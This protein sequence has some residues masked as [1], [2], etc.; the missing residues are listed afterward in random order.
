MLP[1]LNE[2]NIGKFNLIS[3][4]FI[5]IIF[6]VIVININITSKKQDF[7]ILKQEVKNKFIEEKKKEIKFKVDNANQ[8]IIEN[9][10]Q[11]TQVLKNTIKERVNNAYKIANKIY[12]EQTK[13]KSKEEI[14][15]IIKETLR[16]IRYDNGIGYIFMVTMKGKELLFPVAS[17]F[18]NDNVYNLQDKKGDFVIQKE[19]QIV[20]ENKEGFLK[21]FWT[22]PNSHDKEMIYP[23]LTFVK[24]FEKLDLYIGSGMYIDDANKKSQEY[25]KNLLIELNKQNLKEYIIVSELLN[26]DGGNEFAKIIVHPTAIIGKIIGDTKKD[27]YGKE[28]RKE[29]LKGLKDNGQTYLKYSYINPK[30]NIEMSKI[31][32]FVL[33]KQWNWIIGAGFHDDI[34][35]KDINNWQQ[36]L[37]VLIIQNIYLYIGLLI[38]FSIIL[39]LIVFSISKFTNKTILNYKKSVELKQNELNKINKDLEIKIREEVE[40]STKQFKILQEQSKMAA[41]GEMIGNIAHQWRQPLSVISTAATG[42]KVKKEFGIE[43]HNDDMKMLEV[44]NESAQYLSKTID[45]FRDFLKGDTAKKDFYINKILEK[46]LTIEEGVIKNNHLTIVKNFDKD[47]KLHNL[48]H[49]LLQSCVNIINNS[50]DAFENTEEEDRYIFISTK[51]ASEHIEIEIK[52]TAGGIPKNII[53]NIFEPYFTTKHKSQGTGLGLHMTY[54]IINQNMGGLITVK[55]TEYYYNDTD[56]TGAMFTIILP[57]E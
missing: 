15:N 6:T 48:E 49:G 12:N 44:I 18:E 11:T 40:K 4:S 24:G 26:I 9:A 45:S 35:D 41:M 10:K 56:Y 3:T 17:H 16:P 27:L 42:I 54:N 19:I 1:K 25:M 20:K 30:T 36:N 23:K 51:I 8:L 5:L 29:Y 34:I 52:D 46:I 47:I 32:Y 53:E 33:N 21:D 55:N 7:D 43:N 50:K 22:K 31:S 2:Q 57:L 28:Y 13:I 39:F 14:I 37:N 38:L